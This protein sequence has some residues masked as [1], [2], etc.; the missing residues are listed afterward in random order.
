MANHMPVFLMQYD[1]V[2]NDVT[3]DVSQGDNVR[4]TTGGS[5]VS[6]TPRE[7]RAEFTLEDPTG[8]YRPY[9]ASS[10]LYGKAGRNTPLVIA[11]DVVSEDFEDASL[12]VTIGSGSSANAWARST[13]SPH[14]GTYCFKSGATANGA[15]SDAIIEVPT[16]ANLCILW[17]RT[18]CQSSDRLRIST[19]GN[20]RLTVGGTGGSWTQIAV[21]CVPNSVGAR[22]VY[23]RY[24]KDASGTA[25]AD[26]VY[27]DDVRFMNSRIFGEISSWDPDRTLDFDG[28]GR[29]RQWTEV[30]AAGLLRR[31]GSWT[32]PLQSAMTRSVLQFSTLTGFW[33]MEDGSS[34]SA[35]S[36]L[37][38]GGTSG[39]VSEV[40]LG[41]DES[42]GGGSSSARLSN[43][44]SLAGNFLLDTTSGWQISFA[45]RLAAVPSSGTSQKL[46]EWSTGNG[47]TYTLSVNNASYTLN[48]VDSD[49]ASL[50]TMAVGFGTGADP[51]RWITMRLKASQSG[52][53]VA[54]DLNWYPE[55]RDILW[56]TSDTFVGTVSTLSSWRVF[57]NAYLDGGWFAYVYGVAG[58]SD[59]LLSSDMVKSFDGYA[60]ELA[61]DRFLRLLA[62]EGLNRSL[63]G[64]AADTEAM[65]PQRP[66]TLINLLREIRDTDGGLLNDSL[67]E[68]GVT[69]RTRQDLYSQTPALA[70]TYGVEVAP[71]F[72]PTIDDLETHNYITVQRRDGGQF[73]AVDT[74]TEMSVLPPPSGVGVYK[75]DVEVNVDDESRMEQIGFWWLKIGTNPEARY[76]AVTVDLDATPAIEADASAVVPG[77]RITISGHDPDVI[78]LMVVGAVDL[79]KTQKRR[80][81]TYACTPYRQYDVGTYDDS[82][83]RYDSSSTTTGASYS[84]SATSIVFS[85]VNSGDGWS[86]TNEPYDVFINGERMTVT[87]MGSVSG[88]GPY[89]Q[90]ATV[91]RAV[92]GVAKSHASGSPIHVATPARYAL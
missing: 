89:T 90:T 13:T 75:Q 68:I 65:G 8:K 59:E 84:S 29:G 23:V 28:N 80:T 39:T 30:T 69:Y 31:I 56:G 74:T 85:T 48:V 41:D 66:D 19:G 70:L 91:T 43:T 73:V 16:G 36:N 42:P 24:L 6:D 26:A 2:Y 52:S 67:N 60:G 18:D 78:D 14:T 15:F 62:E 25:G 10:P 1:G 77:D 72:K 37:V 27:I 46:I 50:E 63:I 34:A 49:G 38:S 17:Y 5:V 58:T 54:Y 32:E 20:L 61:G 7:S 51:N 21:P 3:A 88:S 4:I 33:P 45:F 81:I 86:T 55:E 40:Q 9:L 87:N 57:G 22:Q 12:N 76:S 64:L 47:Y 92:N 35:L 53:N 11:D 83:K 82:T 71:P 44:S 79:Q